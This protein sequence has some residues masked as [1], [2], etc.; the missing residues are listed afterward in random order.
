MQF[1][2]AVY[3]EFSVHEKLILAVLGN[4]HCLAKSLQTFIHD[5]GSV[6]TSCAVFIAVEERDS[7]VSSTKGE[8][9]TE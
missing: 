9:K 4:N 7:V 5:K 8:L 2:V 6:D 3:V 1:E